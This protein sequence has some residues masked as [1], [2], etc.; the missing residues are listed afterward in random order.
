MALSKKDA[1]WALPTPFKVL[2]QAK[3]QESMFGGGTAVGRGRA[4][5]FWGQNYG[6]PNARIAAQS[7]TDAFAPFAQVR[8]VELIDV[9][10]VL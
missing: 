7:F 6:N 3:R 4:P 9:E 1:W 10:G 2:L 5:Y 8:F